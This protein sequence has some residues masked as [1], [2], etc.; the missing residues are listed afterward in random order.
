MSPTTITREENSIAAVE[1]FPIHTVYYT[2]IEP[3]TLNSIS[4]TKVELDMSFL[5]LEQ[6]YSTSAAQSLFPLTYMMTGKVK[7]EKTPVN[8]KNKIVLSLIEKWLT[9]DSEYDEK[10]W[11]IVKESIERNRL[12]DRRRFDE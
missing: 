5:L 12:S 11:P 9:D 2:S 6:L 10:V 7:E 3:E 8:V 4:S 1:P